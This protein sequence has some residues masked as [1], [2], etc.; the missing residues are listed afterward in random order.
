MKSYVFSRERIHANAKEAFESF[1]VAMKEKKKERHLPVAIEIH[2]IHLG[3]LDFSGQSKSKLFWNTRSMFCACC[4]VE[5]GQ[6][7]N[8]S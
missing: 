4:S 8:K 7:R 2:G 3:A 5:K 6:R 1:P